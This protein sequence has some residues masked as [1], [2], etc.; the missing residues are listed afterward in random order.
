MTFEKGI[1]N[2]MANAMTL[3]ESSNVIEPHIQKRFL[4]KGIT[5]TN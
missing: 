2:E 3:F 5:L 4:A 1:D